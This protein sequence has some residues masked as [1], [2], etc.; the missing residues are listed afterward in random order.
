[1]SQQVNWWAV[2]EFI[3]PMLAAADGWPMAGSPAWCQLDD[4]DARKW[5]ALL[6]A[7]EH[8]VLRVETAQTALAQASR[9]VSAAADWRDVARQIAC[10]RAV[11]IRKEAS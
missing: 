11:Y 1:M 4:A 3:A 2:H 5:A 7:G 6:S 10:R 9:A 8:H